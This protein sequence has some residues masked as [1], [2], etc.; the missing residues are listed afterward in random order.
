MEVRNATT[1]E[2]LKD[3]YNVRRKVFIEEQQV[4]EE[5]EVD[6]HEAE[7]IHFVAYDNGEAV[8]AGRLRVFEDYGKAER[9][10]VLASHRKKG[11]GELIMSKM[12]ERAQAEGKPVLKLNAQTHAEPFYKKIGYV[13]SSDLFYDAGIPH[14]AMKKEL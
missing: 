5:I 6:E 9:V 7:S 3:A 4:P 12:E 13:T 14:V 1:E 10:C 11:V 8:G 2:E